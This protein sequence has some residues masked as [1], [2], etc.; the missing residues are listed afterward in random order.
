MAETYN[1]NGGP[2][3]KYRF[4]K[5]RWVLGRGGNTI[6]QYLQY[7]FSDISLLIRLE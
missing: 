7:F 5:R 6:P 4:P 3:N 1:G 2:V